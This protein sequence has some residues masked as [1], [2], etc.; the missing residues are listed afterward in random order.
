MLTRQ[1][2]NSKSY[3]FLSIMTRTISK[4]ITM[5]WLC[6]L[7]VL[8]L[9]FFSTICSTTSIIVSRVIQQPT[10]TTTSLVYILVIFSFYLVHH[11]EK[12]VDILHGVYIIAATVQRLLSKNERRRCQTLWCRETFNAFEKVP[13]LWYGQRSCPAVTIRYIL[14]VRLLQ[15]QHK[16]AWLQNAKNRQLLPVFKPPVTA[17]S[18]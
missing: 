15:M 4:R 3:A 12:R 13:L 16:Y 5:I 18:S 6:V 10:I 14:H 17:A 2:V 1:N 7:I 9:V 11:E 8:V